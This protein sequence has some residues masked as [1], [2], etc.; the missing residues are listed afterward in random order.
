MKH[1]LTFFSLFFLFTST[2]IAQTTDQLATSSSESSTEAT[3]QENI[4]ER[5]GKVIETIGDTLETR[6]KSAVVGVIEKLT[7]ESVTIKTKS[8]SSETVMI[9]PEKLTVLRLPQLTSATIQDMEIDQFVVVMGY[10]GKEKVLEA[11]RILLSPE[12]L[13]PARHAVVYGVIDSITST[14]IG[15]TMRDGNLRSIPLSKKTVYKMTDGKLPTTTQKKAEF[16]EGKKVLVLTLS[17]ENASASATLVRR[18]E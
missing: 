6:K 3:M 17:S 15:V 1:L 13:F 9:N 2:V 4:R 14:K 10:L 16:I 8:G 5:I 18:I 11:R 7:E 12:I